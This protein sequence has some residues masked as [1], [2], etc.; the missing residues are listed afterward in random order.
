[1]NCIIQL[2]HE[3]P[4]FRSVIANIDLHIVLLQEIDIFHRFKVLLADLDKQMTD[5]REFEIHLFTTKLNNIKIAKFQTG[6]FFDA[7]FSL[8]K[9]AT[10]QPSKSSLLENYFRLDTFKSYLNDQGNLRERKMSLNVTPLAQC[11]KRKSLHVQNFFF[12]SN[13]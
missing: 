4:L 2:F 3:I 13:K 8:I 10:V 1:M 7:F 9:L 12:I 5:P 6:E 11:S